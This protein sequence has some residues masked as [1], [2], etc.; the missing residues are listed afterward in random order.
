MTLGEWDTPDPDTTTPGTTAAGAAPLVVRIVTDTITDRLA[1][2]IVPVVDEALAA[3][4]A[5][6]TT[7]D[8]LHAGA[9]A[10]INQ[11]LAAPPPEPG[12]RYRSVDEFV[13]DLVIPVFRRNVGPRAEARWSAR[14]WESAEAIMRLEAM[15]RAWEALRHD[16]A[17]GISHWL[18][19]HA[20]HHMT[21][22]LS[23]TG[24]FA[25]SQDEAKAS[26]P[27]PYAP[28]PEGLFPPG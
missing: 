10:A 17:T 8:Q 4:L 13:R 7:V 28:P 23:P 25:R 19:D 22:L 26:D 27:L 21:I 12:L 2:I 16:P 1:D 24:P 3:V 11:L 15:W 5:D 20:D 14:W 9:R 6:P 18:R